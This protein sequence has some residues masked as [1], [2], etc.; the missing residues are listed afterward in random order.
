[1]A[2]QQNKSTRSKRGMRRSHDTVISSTISV[3]QVSGETHLRHHITAE[4]FYRGRK[5][6]V[7]SNF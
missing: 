4:G 2:V 7:K 6:I 1:M 5:V 3:D